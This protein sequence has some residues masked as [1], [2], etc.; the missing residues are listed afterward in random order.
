MTPARTRI[1]PTFVFVVGVHV[2]A[3]MSS[4][5]MMMKAMIMIIIAIL[6]VVAIVR[7]T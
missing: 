5:V 7:K 4:W 3:A 2:V 6:I 1:L